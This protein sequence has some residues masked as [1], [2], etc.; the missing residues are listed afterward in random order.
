MP[1]LA[2]RISHIAYRISHIAYRNYEGEIGF[3][4]YLTPKFS[5]FLKNIFS[6][7]KYLFPF[8]KKPEVSVW[9][10]AGFYI[11]MLIPCPEVPV[12]QGLERSIP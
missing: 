4:K 3:V 12:L 9:R 2:Y 1:I 7:E 6:L 11:F 5:L 8:S 10:P